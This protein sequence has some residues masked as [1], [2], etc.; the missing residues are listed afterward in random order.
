MTGLL[1][2]AFF[3]EGA[4]VEFG[5]AVMRVIKVT[6]EVEPGDVTDVPMVVPGVNVSMSVPE[7]STTGGTG[8]V[9]V[10]CLGDVD[11]DGARGF[12][13]DASN[14]GVTVTFGSEMEKQ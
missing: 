4:T 2:F 13:V 6:Y 8:V 12:S 14:P 7:F 5:G 1:T 3:P 9:G 11:S 10:P